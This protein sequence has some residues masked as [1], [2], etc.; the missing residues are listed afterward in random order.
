MRSTQM[1][2]GD[3]LAAAV[4]RTGNP[5][6]VGI[7]PRWDSLPLQVRATAS[8]PDDPAG[9]REVMAESYRRFGEAIIDAV[10]DLVPLVKPQV[11]FFEAMGAPGMVALESVMNHAR[12]RG[13]I[14]CL[15]GKRNDIGSTA[16]AYAAAWL[17]TEG[18]AWGADALTV[19]PYLG[20]DTLEPFT[21]ACRER[22]AG[23]FVLVK[24]SN[25]GSAALQDRSL[26]SLEGRGEGHTVSEVVAGWV[27]RLAVSSVGESG[28]GDVGAVVGAT[29][30]HQLV[31]LRRKM[32]HAWLLVPGYGAQ[33]GGA[34]DVAAAFDGSG[35]GAVINNSRGII[36]AHRSREYAAKFG[37]DRWTD[38]VREATVRMIEDLEKVSSMGR[39]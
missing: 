38:A 7:D 12:R 9:R 13:L 25:P 11:A 3:R 2:F 24:T 16:E 32:P 19:S 22:A 17:G 39:L 37:E 30:P 6:C 4:R 29:Y 21:K 5:V 1:G 35:L 23:I 20:D 26:Q 28:Y 36:F 14:V 18:S 27:E 15:D 34:A 8:L 33:G 31:E 10:A